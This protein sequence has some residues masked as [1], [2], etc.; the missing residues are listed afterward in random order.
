MNI[1]KH[2][3]AVLILLGWSL[4]FGVCSFANG[5][6]INW[7]ETTHD[8]GAFDESLGLVTTVFK[9]VNTGDQPLVVLSARANCGCTTPQYTREAVMPGDTLSLSVSYNA[10]GRPGRFD[11]KVYVTSNADK[12]SVLTI[13][14]TVIGTSNSLKGRYPVDGGKIRL[15][16]SVLPF[17]EVKKGS[18]SSAIL[19]A[20]NASDDTIRPLVA[21]HPKFINFTV[22]PAD[23][24]PGEPF[25]IVGNIN[26]HDKSLWG[27]VTD[28]A[29]VF[30]NGGNHDDGGLSISTVAIVNEDFSGL[31]DDELKKSPKLDL[32]TKNID[33]DI[34]DR[35][36]GKIVMKDMITN[37]GKNPLLI[38]RVFSPDNA[39]TVKV[40]TSTLKNGKSTPL[41]VVIDPDKI[42]AGE[43]LNARITLITNDPTMPTT[44]IRVV[45]EVK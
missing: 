21:G 17:G 45:G 9:A 12:N 31:S 13:T 42:P 36:K 5:P 25:A 41:T 40:G 33:L 43:P 20:Y 38:H 11:K 4:I 44:I 10:S 26:T 3:G 14:G 7:L 27:L 24:P 30:A 16:S 23:V 18:S 22:R 8:F 15:S 35:S 32:Q 34:V 1:G 28:S 39:L 19:R 29:V 2:K 37:K 6:Q